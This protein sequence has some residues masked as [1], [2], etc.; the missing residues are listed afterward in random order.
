M[1]ICISAGHEKIFLS[2]HRKC[3]CDHQLGTCQSQG[4]QHH[5][6]K[7]EDSDHPSNHI[8]VKLPFYR[9]Y[10]TNQTEL[11]ADFMVSFLTLSSYSA[12]RVHSNFYWTTG[13]HFTLHFAH[14][15]T[16]SYVSCPVFCLCVIIC[17]CCTASLSDPVALFAVGT[18]LYVQVYCTQHSFICTSK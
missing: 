4:P 16:M 12:S 13:K 1:R 11:Y 18:A 6:G 9:S 14:T 17:V 2:H 7:E 8:F 10:S 5:Q 15:D 3:H